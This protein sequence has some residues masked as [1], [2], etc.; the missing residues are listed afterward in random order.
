MRD[1]IEVPDRS[2]NLKVK[3]LLPSKINLGVPATLG[4]VKYFDV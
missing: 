4:L 3:L 1:A 2:Q